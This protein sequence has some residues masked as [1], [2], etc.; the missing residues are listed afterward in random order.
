MVQIKVATKD[1][2]MYYVKILSSVIDF[3]EYC[4]ENLYKSFV[5]PDTNSKKTFT[6]EMPLHP[7]S[8]QT[9]DP[10]EQTDIKGEKISNIKHF[11]GKLYVFNKIPV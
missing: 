10:K 8:L 6:T 5:F 4:T 7:T 11:Q 3:F 2:L 9:P 1:Y